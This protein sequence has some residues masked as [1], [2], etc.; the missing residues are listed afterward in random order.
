MYHLIHAVVLQIIYLPWAKTAVYTNEKTIK[1]TI[2][3]RADAKRQRRNR[4]TRV[5]QL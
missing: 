3:V 4:L 5:A 1:G 2:T